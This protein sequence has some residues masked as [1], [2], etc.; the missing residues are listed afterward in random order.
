MWENKLAQR[1]ASQK[2]MPLGVVI[3]RTPGVTRWAKWCWNA[4]S[5]V[6]G[7]GSA[8]WQVLRS[9]GDVIDY[10]AATCPLTLW[11]TDTEAYLTGL[12]DPIPSIYV[13]MRA[14]TEG[15]MPYEV[16]LVTASPYEAQDYADC[17]EELIEKVA[18]PEGLVAWIR[19]FADEHHE[20]EVFVKRRRDRVKTTLKE[21]GRGD[22][23]IA[24]ISDVYR[25]PG[26]A[27][28]V[29]VQ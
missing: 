5:V 21:D 4:V 25:S 1:R 24:Q 15:D 6:P 20:D 10:L 18:M 19:D 13:V 28:K 22:A 16:L 17:G 26:L 23:R 9:D 2:T 12:N 27:R 11:S 7:A 14:A 8:N 3:R 29:R